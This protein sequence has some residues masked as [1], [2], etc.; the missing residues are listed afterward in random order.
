MGVYGS[1]RSPKH[2]DFGLRQHKK[3]W[4]CSV[5]AIVCLVVAAATTAFWFVALLMA[6]LG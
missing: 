2:D 5:F 3:T 6:S 1:R 4:D